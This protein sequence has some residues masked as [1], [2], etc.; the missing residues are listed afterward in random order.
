MSLKGVPWRRTGASW[1]VEDGGEGVAMCSE[2]AEF[3][4]VLCLLNIDDVV[5]LF[6]LRE[7]GSWHQMLSNTET[8]LDQV[9]GTLFQPW[10]QHS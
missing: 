7:Q 1:E 10:H 4:D 6:L 8:W 9:V 2:N 5:I 3:N